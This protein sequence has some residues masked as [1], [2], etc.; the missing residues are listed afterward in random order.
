MYF[1]KIFSTKK[2]YIV[3][4]LSSGALSFFVAKDGKIKYTSKKNINFAKKAG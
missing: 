4:S 2:D 3:L 1:K